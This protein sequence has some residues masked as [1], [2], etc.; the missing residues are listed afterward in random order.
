MYD[1]RLEGQ[2]K[3]IY[4]KYHKRFITY[5]IYKLYTY[6]LYTN[7]DWCNSNITGSCPVNTG[8]NSVSA[9]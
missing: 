1:E 7:A 4:I 8:A 6:K 5:N 9:Q 2:K 3:N